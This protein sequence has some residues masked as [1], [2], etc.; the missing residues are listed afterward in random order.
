VIQFE[1]H[2]HTFH[3]E[4]PI[5]VRRDAQVPIAEFEEPMRR[6][7]HGLPDGRAVE[8][9]GFAEGD[10]DDGIEDSRVGAEG[11]DGIDERF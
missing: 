6:H 7:S 2:V 5:E 4:G 10:A 8:L 9:V 11:S 1:K 3:E